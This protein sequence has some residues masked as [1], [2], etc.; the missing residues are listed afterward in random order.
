MPR[1]IHRPISITKESSTSTL[2]PDTMATTSRSHAQDAKDNPDDNAESV[3]SMEGRDR[4]RQSLLSKRRSLALA[5]DT[6][7]LRKDIE[8]MTALVEERVCL[9]GAPDPSK[10]PKDIG[11]VCD[12]LFKNL[13]I[14]PFLKALVASAYDLFEEPSEPVFP[15]LFPEHISILSVL[16]D[17]SMSFAL[18]I[19]TRFPCLKEEIS[20]KE[21]KKL[22]AVLAHMHNFTRE[23]GHHRVMDMT[24]HSLAIRAMALLWKGKTL[25][26]L[27]AMEDEIISFE[28][29][30]GKDAKIYS[31]RGALLQIW[32][33]Y[34]AEAGGHIVNTWLR[35][36]CKEGKSMDTLET[37]QDFRNQ[38]FTNMQSLGIIRPMSMT[39]ASPVMKMKFLDIMK[40]RGCGDDFWEPTLSSELK[41]INANAVV[42]KEETAKAGL[43]YC[44]ELV[45]TILAIL[46]KN[47]DNCPN[48]LFHKHKLSE[49]T[50]L[51]SDSFKNLA[52]YMVTN[53]E[54]VTKRTRHYKQKATALEA[55]KM[56]RD[57]T[58]R[59]TSLI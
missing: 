31:P 22:T 57:R 48:C 41:T 54:K 11:T 52:A 43:S 37:L 23:N 30:C 29:A 49:C 12:D 19:V 1:D 38:V 25:E 50:E 26:G 28:K 18:K 6:N 45:C 24:N 40:S 10:Y 59:P 3:L 51:Q 21:T 34:P 33:G 9:G 53:Y 44:S 14:Y 17:A 7:E 58:Q 46:K 55:N 4:V 8:L 20:K 39:S 32:M 35:A 36:R 16:E 2:T 13:E 27:R 5:I 15:Q 47:P 56:Y 42:K